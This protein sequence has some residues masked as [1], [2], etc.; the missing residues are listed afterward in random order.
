MEQKPKNFEEAAL[1]HIPKEFI[2]AMAKETSVEGLSGLSPLEAIMKEKQKTF[3]G[4][5]ALVSAQPEGEA[6]PKQEQKQFTPLAIDGF[7]INMPADK[8]EA[9][10]T[11]LSYIFARMANKDKKIAKILDQFHFKMYDVNGQ[12]IYAPKRKKK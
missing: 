9:G 2:L 1:S 5:G 3:N 8:F 11:M 10:V 4:P 6:Q 7:V 12:E